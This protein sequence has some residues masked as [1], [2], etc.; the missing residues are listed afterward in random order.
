MTGEMR[1]GECDETGYST[2]AGKFMPHGADGLE[3]EISNHAVEYFA[4]NALIA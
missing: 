3:S 1:F 2:L 4:Q